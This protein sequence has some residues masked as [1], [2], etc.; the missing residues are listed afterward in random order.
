MTTTEIRPATEVKCRRCHGTGLEPMPELPAREFDSEEQRQLL[1]RMV[2][3]G[4]RRAGA[5]RHTLVGRQ[6]LD[7]VYQEVRVQAAEAERIGVTRVH[8]MEA[9]G[10]SKAAFYKILSGETGAS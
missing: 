2:E 4:K 8:M 7:D 9:F 3:L 1:E 5:N 6:T 10:V